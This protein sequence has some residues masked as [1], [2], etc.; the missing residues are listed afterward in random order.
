M[1]TNLN[2]IETIF[3]LLMENRSFDHMLGYLSMPSLAGAYRSVNDVNGLKEDP[4]WLQQFA[5]EWEGHNYWPIPLASPRIADPPHER[6]NIQLQM[7]GPD[8]SGR[9]PLNGFVASASGTSDVMNYQTPVTVP[10][11]DFFARNYRICDRWFSCIPAGTQP[12]RL[13]AMSGHSLIDTNQ[14]VLPN[15]LLAYDWLNVHQVRWRVYHQ[16]F[17][18]FFSM[19]PRWMPEIATSDKFRPFDRFAIDMELEPDD[20]FP[21]VIFIEPIYTD[22][23]HAEAEGTDDHSPS[24]VYG[25]QCLMHDVYVAMVRTQHW[26]H[27]ILIV[28]YDEHGGF[29]D[30]EQPIQLET[31]VPDGRYRPFD[32]SGIRVPAAIVSPFVSDGT[33]FHGNLDHTSILKFLGQRFGMGGG[34]S[35]EVDKR[36]LV[37][38]VSDA[39]DLLGSPRAT[40]PAPPMLSSIQ[41]QLST[42]PIPLPNSGAMVDAFDKVHREMKA[43]YAY[44]L[45]TKFPAS[46]VILG[47]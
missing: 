20:T 47:L 13:M 17:F 26:D 25:G 2:Q 8:T 1:P 28:T 33:V 35:P 27:S 44:H 23:P 24:S 6:I 46:R 41:R 43:N 15:Q 11:L 12:N 9:F 4:A 31:A 36:A 3:I 16:G 30:H 19:M 10:I 40:A 34:Y 39:L 21:Q 5:N 7:G 32:T 18:P 45:A 22:A 38:S 42:T 29:F 14:N 37:G